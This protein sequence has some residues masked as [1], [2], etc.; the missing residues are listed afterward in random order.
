MT[1][2]D[3]ALNLSDSDSLTSLQLVTDTTP[4]NNTKVSKLHGLLKRRLQLCETE[5]RI[6]IAVE[7]LIQKYRTKEELTNRT[8]VMHA[9]TV[10]AA[11]Y[12]C[13]SSCC[14]SNDT[15]GTVGPC[16][17]PLCRSSQ[18][19]AFFC[20]VDLPAKLQE[21]L[22][23]LNHSVP[24]TEDESF[25]NES[26]ISQSTTA[27]CILGLD[28][29]SRSTAKDASTGC[30]HAKDKADKEKSVDCVD[31]EKRTTF[32]GDTRE[33]RLLT[34]LLCRHA[35]NGQ[36]RLTEV[37]VNRL[38]SVLDVVP[39]TCDPV[40]LSGTVCKSVRKSAEIPVAHNFRTRSCRQSVFVLT[41]SS[42]RHLARSAGMLFTIPG[43]SSVSKK[44]DSGWMHVGPRPLFC[45]SWQ[46]RT[47][48]AC[49][50]SAVAV[51]LRVLWCCIRW[52][53]MSC[54]SCDTEDVK[55][56][57]ESD[58]VTTTTILDRRDVGQDG[59]RSEYL[60]RRV[61]AP[62]AADDDL[63]IILHYIILLKIGTNDGHETLLNC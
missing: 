44:A 41:P 14:I 29:N 26:S 49:N 37:I 5:D 30:A 40:C 39:D 24:N 31:L 47:A 20:T 54:N 13:Y 12:S 38:Q 8:A 62:V 2:I 35:C 18:E 4:T 33:L 17:S 61:S 42:L 53:D 56:T 55:V 10:A 25:V 22:Q 51:Q 15:E 28:C 48:S 50:L 27:E 57:S 43:F 21:D 11:K 1:A 59:L 60:V 19:Q 36:I 52:D 45:T 32:C 3:A 46:Y 6:K 23:R 9:V 16:Y 63:G 7:D 34:G 58:V